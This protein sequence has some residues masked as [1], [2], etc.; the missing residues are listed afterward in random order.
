LT[1]GFLGGDDDPK[2]QKVSA[3]KLDALSDIVE[4]AQNEGR[5]IVIIARFTAE[6][7]AIKSML[8]KQNIAYSAVSGETK[9]RAEQVRQFQENPEVTVF[10]G[11]I[12]T[13]GLGITLTAAST[14]VFYSL[15]YNMANF[16]QSKARVHRVGQKENCTYIYLTAKGTVDE[17]ILKILRE[18]ANLAKTL[19]D[20]YRSGNNP[21][22]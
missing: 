7:A 21:F 14:L 5:K 6:I 15:D 16:E 10:I 9:D 18:K 17:K 1:G 3:A 8:D 22:L 12:A 2:P 20:D 19:V 4:E 13:A 11:Q